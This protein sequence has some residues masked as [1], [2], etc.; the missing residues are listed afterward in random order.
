MGAETEPSDKPGGTLDQEQ[1]QPDDIEQLR[2]ERDA[3]LAKLDQAG[4]RAARRARFRRVV[5]G[6][7]VVLFAVLVPVTTVATW[8]HRTV[9][10]TDA[11]VSTVAPIASDPAVT[12]AV[13]REVTDQAYAALD[14]QQIIAGALPPKAAFLA[15][16]I[17]NGAKGAIE[18]AVNKVLLSPQ[19]QEL[20]TAAN[21]FAHAQLVAVLRG[22]T[23]TL[24][25]TNGKVVLNLVPLLNQ[26]LKGASGFVSGVVGKPVTLPTISG[27]ELPSAAC[28]KIATAL[29][30]PIPSTCGQIPLFSAAKLNNARH[31]VKAFDRIVIVLLIVTPL[32]AIAALWLSRRRR[33]TLLQLT[34][35]SMLA[36]V[37][38]RRALMWEQSQL[39]NLGK[40]ANRAARSA[41]LQQVLGGLYDVT[42]WLLLA[43]LIVVAV[44]LLTGPYRWAVS[45]RS[46]IATGA[47]KAGNLASAGVHGVTAGTG[48]DRTVAWVRRHIELLSIAGAVVG[49]ILLLAINVSW[50]GALLI[51]VLLGLYEWW[52]QRL[53]PRDITLPPSSPPATSSTNQQMTRP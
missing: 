21:R 30:R 13:S 51:L 26:A 36:L 45:T 25:T 23:T 44:A 27:N 16:P 32:L 53:R 43:G 35:G 17:A 9:L 38:V 20:W 11:Y 39:L 2:A 24:Q 22:D 14:P 4:R 5:V 49:L 47:R 31:A 7:L 3:A 52:L 28:Q 33:R 10:N 29:N 1:E 50:W 40:P 34:I 6:V 48:S 12:Q 46:G 37:V 41:I 18:S 42:W 15:G 19:F 8:T